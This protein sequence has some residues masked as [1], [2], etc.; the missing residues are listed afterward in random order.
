MRLFVSAI[1]IEFGYRDADVITVDRR[2][3]S[4][5]IFRFINAANRNN[6]STTL[7]L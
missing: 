6:T 2:E 7:P 5:R 4:P 1:L 3:F